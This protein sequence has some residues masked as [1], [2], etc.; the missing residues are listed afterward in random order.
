M[1]QAVVAQLNANAREEATTLC[2]LTKPIS[3][4]VFPSTGSAWLKLRSEAG[5]QQPGPTE[6]PD[7]QENPW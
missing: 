1:V 3:T 7:H 5:G 4:T 6:S 2:G